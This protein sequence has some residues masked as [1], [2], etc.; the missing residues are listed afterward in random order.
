MAQSTRPRVGFAR[1]AVT[2]AGML[3]GFGV[4]DDLCGRVLY[5]D[6][7]EQP[8]V[9][10]SLD[11]MGL[12]PGRS[13]A[14]KSRLAKACRIPADRTVI[15]YSHT[16]AG[17][18][19]RAE[20]LARLLAA[21]VAEARRKAR[22]AELAYRRVDVGR[23]YS[24]NRRAVVGH[25]LGAVSILFNRN[26]TVDLKKGT[27]EVGEQIRDFICTGRNI[28]SPF[29]LEPERDPQPG[30][31]ALSGKQMALLKSIPRNVYL[32]GP[33]DPHLEW[34]AFRTKRGRSLGSIVRFSAHPVIWRKSITGRIS[35]DYPGVLCGAIEK[36]T[37]APAL[38][39]NG[40]CGDVKP[41]Y[42]SNS[43]AEMVRVG[44]SL[45]NELLRRRR[46]LT[47]QALE[48]VTL[49]GPRE[50]FAVHADVRK[51]AGRWPVGKAAARHASL[52]RRGTDPAAVKRAL[53]W[54]LRC[55]GNGEI[56]WHRGTI[57]L[58]FHF[59]GFNDVGVLGL[60]NE[61]W[62]EI[63]LAVKHAC[64]GKQV[65]VGANCD[66]VTNYVPMSGALSLGGYEAM[67]S[68]LEESAGERYAAI[69]AELVDQ[70]L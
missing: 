62:C 27:E 60:P 57:T 13:A 42:P 51:Y 70:N 23:R 63:G 39:V 55:W 69:G 54:A 67:N 28:W 5:A 65:I 22:P 56:D 49:L 20:A 46:D 50:R 9:L 7:G 59:V 41:L 43:E 52:A 37:G 14:L 26:I 25:G 4:R 6:A 17:A 8:L 12:T 47:W 44:R 21:A 66:V 35:A 36:A 11:A 31:R 19:F 68:M 1:V 45:A 30:Q 16:H 38:F 58:P 61:V 18:E 10:I 29:Y 40:P 24:V 34:L 2:S 64:R 53:D 15:F 48:R 3:G 33:V 32:E